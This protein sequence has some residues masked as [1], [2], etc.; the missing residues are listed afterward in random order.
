MQKA[1]GQQ[2]SAIANQIKNQMKISESQIAAKQKQLDSCI[3]ANGLNNLSATLK[4]TLTILMDLDEKA[5]KPYNPYGNPY[6][7][8]NVSIQLTYQRWVRDQVVVNSVSTVRYWGDKFGPGL[9]YDLVNWHTMQQNSQFVSYCGEVNSKT[10]KLSVTLTLPVRLE[11]GVKQGQTKG[12]YSFG[13]SNL[14]IALSTDN[15][16][17]SRL[18]KQGKITLSGEGVFMDGYLN[19]HKCR[20][21]IKGTLLPLPTH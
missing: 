9:P 6:Q 7:D 21:W 17:G 1:T 19:G 10:G 3:A 2:K 16:G 14:L 13:F 18:D 11:W 15:S 8:D 12:N 20:M 4:G 5:G